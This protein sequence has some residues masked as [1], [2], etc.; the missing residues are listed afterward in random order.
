MDSSQRSGKQLSFDSVSQNKRYLERRKS[1]LKGRFR[2]VKSI[3]VFFLSLSVCTLVVTQYWR[4]DNSIRQ[5]FILLMVGQVMSRAIIR[6]CA[7]IHEVL[8]RCARNRP[9][10][11]SVFS[12]WLVEL[13]TDLQDGFSFWYMLSNTFVTLLFLYTPE[14]F[15]GMWASG[16][17]EVRLLRPELKTVELASLAGGLNYETYYTTGQLLISS[18]TSPKDVYGEVSYRHNEQWIL[19]RK[20]TLWYE[21]FA[22]N[23]TKLRKNNVKEVH[24]TV[25]DNEVVRLVEAPLQNVEKES[26]R[27][28]GN[29]TSYGHS[30]QMHTCG[31]VT[32]FRYSRGEEDNDAKAF[33]IHYGS[34]TVKYS[35][36]KG[37]RRINGGNL[38]N[39][40]TV[41]FP[42]PGVFWEDMG[43]S[44][45]NAVCHIPENR[46]EDSIPIL[47]RVMMSAMVRVDWIKGNH[48]GGFSEPPKMVEASV[49]KAV[50]SNIPLAVVIIMVVCCVVLFADA[51]IT[52]FMNQVGSSA[53]RD[54]MDIEIDRKQ[55]CGECVRVRPGEPTRWELGSKDELLDIEGNDAKTAET[56]ASEHSSELHGPNTSDEGNNASR[57]SSD[58][59][60]TLDLGI[61]A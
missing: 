7:E 12:V 33:Q 56:S 49:S 8:C 1:K 50:T 37:L 21:K 58:E 10:P 30:L 26:C 47:D 16:R 24:I 2:K 31:I 3:T 20:P 41:K 45:L 46:P 60:A 51:A 17:I 55:G 43:M 19:P 40:E 14:Q 48:T 57:K 34:T 15:V 18:T 35:V 39:V 27:E 25:M 59:E 9:M 54:L 5:E 42:N 52:L 53:L 23:N 11:S 29:L 32:Q 44:F 36:E 61:T 38:D 22:E 6:I 28:I 13:D 4:G